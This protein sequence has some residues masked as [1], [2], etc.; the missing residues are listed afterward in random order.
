MHNRVNLP[1]VHR[2]QPSPRPAD[3]LPRQKP[4]HGK[5]AQ[6]NYQ[7]R[8]EQFNLPIQ[9]LGARRN[10]AR[11]RIPIVGRTALHH[12]RNVHLVAGHTD[13]LQQLLQKT[14]RRPHKRPPLPIFLHPGAFP[15]QQQ[16]G[17]IRPLAGHR[18]RPPLMQRAVGAFPDQPGN[19]GQRVH[20]NMPPVG[21]CSRSRS[22][23]G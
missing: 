6:R 1:P 8:V 7:P 9:I 18:L 15:D 14:A 20:S 3:A 16:F 4:G 21:P 11:R 2:A 5:T 12:I 22:R 23:I 17:V 13:R 10:F 19:V